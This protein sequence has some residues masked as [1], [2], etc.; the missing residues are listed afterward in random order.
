MLIHDSYVPPLLFLDLDDVIFLN[1]PYGGYDLAAKDHPSDLWERLWHRPAL[2]LLE[3]VIASHQP[4][5]VLTTSWLRFLQLDEAKVLFQRSGAPWLAEA[6]HPRGEALQARGWTRLQAIDGWL[7]AHRVSEPYAI[8]DDA[9]SG[10]G[11]A[12]S[13]HDKERR[14]VLCD[15]EVGLQP[16][17]VP[18]LIRALST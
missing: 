1:R 12:G 16:H 8:L 9:L 6:L 3:G 2:D 13:R 4:R 10:T 14:V 15:V 7:D 18:R 11:L 17:H 5:V